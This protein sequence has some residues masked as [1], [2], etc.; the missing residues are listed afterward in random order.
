MTKFH[1][2][3]NLPNT[4]ESLNGIA[5]V[6]HE[7]A[8]GEISRVMRT[9]DPVSVEVAAM[10][11]GI[12]GFTI[13]DAEPPEPVQVIQEPVPAPPAPPPTPEPAAPAPRQRGARA[14]TAEAA[15]E[16]VAE[17]APEPEAPAEAAAPVA[18]EEVF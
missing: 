10:F 17:P 6:E 8:Y 11:K 13:E 2:L 1:V 9:A 5:F 12:P 15:P 3:C 4:S 16:A 18:D 14:S 7:P